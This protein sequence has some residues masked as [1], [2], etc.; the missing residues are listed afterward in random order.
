MGKIKQNNIDVTKVL[1]R[2][3]PDGKVIA[4][5]PELIGT[6]DVSTCLNY[7]LEGQHGTGKATTKGTQHAFPE[8]YQELFN[9]L[10]QI[11]YRMKV[12]SRISPQM[13][14]KRRLLYILNLV[15]LT[16][17]NCRHSH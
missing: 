1:F 9:E 8:E 15:C 4:I 5:F 12:V 2:K 17:V 3:F 10:Y 14:R 7:V 13:D 6:N 16:T 11:G